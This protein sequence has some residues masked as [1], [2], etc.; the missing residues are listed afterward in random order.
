MVMIAARDDPVKKNALK[1]EPRRA[2]SLGW[3]SSNQQRPK[4]DPPLIKLEAPTIAGVMPT[5]MTARATMN[6]AVFTEPA[7]DISV[8]KH[9]LTQ[10]STEKQDQAT[11]LC[12]SSSTESI[13]DDRN[14]R[15]RQNSLT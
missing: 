5:P 12:T 6:M 15:Y 4:Q 2:L 11:N 14:N 1:R 9:R 10:T 8:V 7:S 3:A 13:C